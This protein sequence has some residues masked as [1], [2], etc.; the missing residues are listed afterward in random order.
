MP[1]RCHACGAGLSPPAG[2]AYITCPY[3]G[4]STP[5]DEAR[6]GGGRAP[7]PPSSARRRGGSR[8]ALVVLL[9]AVVGGAAALWFVQA[10]GVKLLREWYSPPCVVDANGDEVLDVAGWS[11]GP[12]AQRTLTVVD[13]RTGD[14]LWTGDGEYPSEAIVLCAAPDAVAVA[15]PDFTVELRDAR[16]GTLS[17]TAVLPDKVQSYGRGARCVRLWTAAAESTGIRTDDAA[18]APCETDEKLTWWGDSIAGPTGPLRPAERDGVRFEIEARRGGTPLL[19]VRARR[20]DETIWQTPLNLAAEDASALPL[21]V[22]PA[23][24]VTYGVRP[25]DADAGWLV[26]L[27]PATGRPRFERRQASSWADDLQ[28]FTWNGRYVLAMWG[29]GLHAYDPADGERRWHI[30]GR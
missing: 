15:R 2:S 13:G 16:T 26:G 28:G 12:S 6:A 23:S 1:T 9:L 22:T 20:G 18:V 30:G 21:V 19:T 11:G 5:V 4:A 3:C 10:G 17:G 25:G 24:V 14:T 8:G 29:F 7:G 27:D